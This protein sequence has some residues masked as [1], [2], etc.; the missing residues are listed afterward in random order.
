MLVAAY[1]ESSVVP[2][3]V[4]ML[5]EGSREEF[6]AEAVMVTDADSGRLHFLT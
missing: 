5:D 6:R 1:V 2:A 3:I 4:E